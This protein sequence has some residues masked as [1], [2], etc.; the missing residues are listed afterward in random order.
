MRAALTLVI[1]ILLGACAGRAAVDEAPLPQAEPAPAPPHEDLADLPEN[2]RGVIGGP[3]DDTAFVFEPEP[4]D[5][6]DRPIVL[7]GVP[8]IPEA[9]RRELAPYLESRRAQIAAVG[10]GGNPVY[11]LSRQDTVTQLYAVAEPKAELVAMTEGREPI[12]QAAVVAGGR[13][14]VLRRDRGGDEQYQILRRDLA[15]GEELMLTVPGTRSGPFRVSADGQIAF[16]N[17]HRS[18]T[19]MD[20][21]RAVHGD[22]ALLFPRQGQWLASGWSPGGRSLLLR[23][24][25]SIDDSAIFIAD[26]ERKRI[27]PLPVEAE[28][29]AFRD[30]RYVAGGELIAFV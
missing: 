30:A 12:A 14:L 5:P 20:I 9:L 7:D 3:I 23:H 18:A 22:V 29:A 25:R 2:A 21:Y 16:A 17:N 8:D 27:E 28:T 13:E 26:V 6:D 1:S 15:S 10:P 4:E 19:D 11:V 24:Y